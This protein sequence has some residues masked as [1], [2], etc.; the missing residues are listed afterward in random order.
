[1]I[2]RGLLKEY[3]HTL[4]LFLRAMDMVAV[5]IAGIVAYV[6]RFDTWVIS[7]SYWLV[8]L[9]ATICAPI[10]L[11]FCHIYSSTRGQGFAAHCF[12]LIQ[13]ICLL[14]AILLGLSFLTKSGELFSRYWFLLWLGM[15]LL[16]L[17]SLRSLL[18]LFLRF[19][20]SQG[21]NERRVI[22]FGAGELGCKFAENVQQALWTGFKIISFVDDCA[23]NKPNYFNH[24]PIIQTPAHLGAYLKDEMID[25]VWIALPLREEVRVKEIL[26]EMRHH[27]ITT[28]FVLDIFGLDLLHHS[29][30]DLAG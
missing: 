26:H 19:M 12:H 27:T 8:I 18:L 16:L 30:T 23:H 5:L 2:P 7:S 22:I 29:I 6:I 20:R 21:L 25:E 11:S 9:I 1:M 10:A 17:L 3:S 24:I 4:S 14:S 28:R 15:S 13:A